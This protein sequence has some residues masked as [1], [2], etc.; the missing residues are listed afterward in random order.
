MDFEIGIL[1]IIFQL[2]A[3]VDRCMLELW[4]LNL[5]VVLVLPRH[6]KKCHDEVRLFR[7]CPINLHRF[8]RICLGHLEEVAWGE[9]KS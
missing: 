8:F 5:G 9:P 6:A 2:A 3:K 4:N 7:E 1:E